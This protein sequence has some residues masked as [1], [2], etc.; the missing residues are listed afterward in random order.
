M[1]TVVVARKAF[2]E[3]GTTTNTRLVLPVM[4]MLLCGCSTYLAPTLSV[5]P[6][7]TVGNGVGCDSV[8]QAVCEWTED[9]LR[10]L[11]HRVYGEMSGRR[12]WGPSKLGNVDIVCSLYV[13]EAGTVDSVRSGEVEPDEVELVRRLNRHIV[14]RTIPDVAGTE[15]H[16]TEILLSFRADPVK[17]HWACYV[18]LPMVI[19]ATVLNTVRLFL[20]P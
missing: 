5:G 17:H 3:G 2:R 11:T 4:A 15:G 8:T 6:V 12:L 1:L 7:D 20:S 10:T 13:S 19:S 14:G 18:V 9:R 16:A